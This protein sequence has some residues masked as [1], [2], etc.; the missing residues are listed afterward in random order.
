MGCGLSVF[1]RY[2]R[3]VN[4]DGSEMDIHNILQI[5]R[6]ETDEYLAQKFEKTGNA[7]ELPKEE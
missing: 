4:A 2:K 1:S 7:D 6:Q 3:I 5:I